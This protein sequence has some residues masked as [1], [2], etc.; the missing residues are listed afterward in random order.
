MYMLDLMGQGNQGH[1][2]ILKK[3]TNIPYKRYTYQIQIYIMFNNILIDKS[4]KIILKQH[5]KLYS[6]F[7]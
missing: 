7:A 2:N 4:L 6:E 5:K 3:E 1:I